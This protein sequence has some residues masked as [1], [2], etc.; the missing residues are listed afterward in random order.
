MDRHNIPDVDRH[1]DGEDLRLLAKRVCVTYGEL[2]AVK[3]ADLAVKRGE[4]VAIV[5]ESGSG[6]TSLARAMIGLVEGQGELTINGV[7]TP[8]PTDRRSLESKRAVQLVFQDPIGSLNPQHR[9][10]D[11]VEEPLKQHAKTINS[12]ER[13][14]MVRS[15]LK[16]VSLNPDIMKRFPHQL[17][18]GQ[19]QR[20]AI[21]RA[22]ITS[23]EILI[24]DEA[25]AALDGPVREEVLQLLMKLQAQTGLSIVFISHDL[26]LV[27]RIAHRVIVMYLGTVV[28]EAETT[29]LFTDP[30]HPYTRALIDAVPVPDPAYRPRPALSGEV[31]SVLAPPSGCGFH[32]RCAYAVTACEERSPVLET[33]AHA[34]VRCHRAGEIDLADGLPDYGVRESAVATALDRDAP[35]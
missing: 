10:Q 24:C 7:S 30:Q 14:Q 17:S 21:A 29:Q 23:P 13:R 34:K 12:S 8:F 15:A 16:G 4:T 33:V 19:A 28:E 2:R 35:Q 25:A 27:S 11:I 18:G 9:V 26:G 6:K 1:S 31:P 5:G 20:V 32:P 3:S 22:L